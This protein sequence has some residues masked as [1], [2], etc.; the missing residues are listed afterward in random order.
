MMRSSLFL[1]PGQAS[2]LIVLAGT[3]FEHAMQDFGFQCR[4]DTE[5]TLVA[6]H[7][8][9]Q[10]S[11]V[12]K[13]EI[14]SA[15][16]RSAG[17]SKNL[18]EINDASGLGWVGSTGSGVR[19]LYIPQEHSWESLQITE[20]VF[21]AMCS[22]M[23]I[24]DAFR[25]TIMFMGERE[26]EVEVAPPI[27][28]WTSGDPSAGERSTP[29]WETSYVLR[30]VEENHRPDSQPWSLR[31]FAVYNK[32]HSG[33]IG[34]SWVLI[35]PSQDALADVNDFLEDKDTISA[36]ASIS[37][38][39]TL[40]DTATIYW[41]PYLVFLTTKIDEQNLRI[42]FAD[43]QCVRLVD[44]AADGARLKL[45]ELGDAVT[46]AIL[47]LQA[48]REVMRSLLTMLKCCGVTIGSADQEHSILRTV[49]TMSADIEAYLRQ[50]RVLREKV[51]TCA[52]IVSSFA[53]L[54]S[55]QSLRELAEGARIDHERTAA[56][57]LKAQRD[58][59]AVKA[60]TVIALIYLPT[61]VVLVSQR[62]LA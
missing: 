28:R 35:S 51:A 32:T 22:S 42:K 62:S 29:G 34:A 11:S 43:P 41:R 61:T 56:M 19:I 52:Q 17:M 59:A 20:E 23:N 39:I 53:E 6:E 50:L 60:L 45:K 25:H 12:R 54:T 49:N 55:G 30:Y 33:G 5:T 24:F 7:V 37:L 44:L 46:D 14:T 21:E 47:A 15:D 16:P 1:R 57:A 9:L 3:N 31:Q 2:R 48:N 4:T 58:A 18:L 40:I 38:H 8:L 10:P 26:R 13:R 36:R 27:M